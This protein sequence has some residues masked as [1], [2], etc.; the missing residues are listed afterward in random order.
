MISAAETVV[1]RAAAPR[2]GVVTP[3]V[4][5]VVPVLNE[6]ALIARFL[7]H[8][9]E[10]AP[11]AELIVVDGGSNDS[12][13]SMAKSLCDRFVVSEPGRAQQLNAGARV[14]RGDVLWFLHADSELP[15]GCLEEIRR[16]VADPRISGGY[17]RI[18]LPKGTPFTA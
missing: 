4:S 3:F 2:G 10:R 16:A 11:G 5:I 9:R 14:A 17:F 6:A 15:D 13:R 18:R 12:T 8:L 1:V 7:R